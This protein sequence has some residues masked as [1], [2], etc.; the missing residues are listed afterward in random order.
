MRRHVQAQNIYVHVDADEVNRIRRNKIHCHAAGG[1]AFGK[2]YLRRAELFGHFRVTFV[3]G[4]NDD[5]RHVH[6][7]AK[8]CCHQTGFKIFRR[9]NHRVEIVNA[10]LFERTHVANVKT[11]DACQ[12]F[13]Q[14]RDNIFVLVDAEHV[15]AHFFERQ[16]NVHAETSQPEHR[17]IFVRQNF[18]P[19]PI[20][21]SSCG[22]F[23]LS[24]R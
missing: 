3:N 9:D 6:F 18:S 20:I 15:I 8:H 7:V 4:F 23:I 22:Y 2:N 12:S 21:M 14:I 10:D 11:Y 1:V 19:Q 13:G 17:K 16:G 24:S 5:F